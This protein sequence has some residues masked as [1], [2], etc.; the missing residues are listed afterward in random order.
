MDQDKIISVKGELW[1][2]VAGRLASCAHTFTITTA[3][4]EQ[5]TPKLVNAGQLKLRVLG[6]S[7]KEAKGAEITFFVE[8]PDSRSV[9]NSPA[10]FEVE[11]IPM[12]RL[13]GLPTNFISGSTAPSTPFPGSVEVKEDPSA[14]RPTVAVIVRLPD[15]RS[16]QRS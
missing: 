4:T 14:E 11:I 7:D 12:L 6:M 13:L 10:L 5:T 3:L 15:L 1:E 16:V 2:F 9:L 8:A